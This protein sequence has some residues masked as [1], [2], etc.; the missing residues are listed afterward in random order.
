MIEDLKITYQKLHLKLSVL[1]L[2]FSLF[3]DIV[4]IKENTFYLK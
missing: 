4:I 1:K 2:D 3:R